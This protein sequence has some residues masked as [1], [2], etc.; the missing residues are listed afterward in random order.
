MVPMVDACSILVSDFAVRLLLME[1]R[2]ISE[3]V[4]GHGD[5]P[6]ELGHVTEILLEHCRRKTLPF[7]QLF[8]MSSSNSHSCLKLVKVAMFESTSTT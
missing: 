6:N 3:A 5:R 2:E 4:K 7:C 1:R 8:V